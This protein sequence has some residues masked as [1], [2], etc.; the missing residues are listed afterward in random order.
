M[1]FTL[2]YS[3]PL[4]SKGNPAA[5]HDIR[6]ALHPQ[7]KNLWRQNP[8]VLH[9]DW[10]QNGESPNHGVFLKKVSGHEFATTVNSFQKLYAELDF[11]CFGPKHQDL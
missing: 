10:I 6:L 4:P 11:L 2:T 5:K 3:G 8:L 7:L 9:P 1:R